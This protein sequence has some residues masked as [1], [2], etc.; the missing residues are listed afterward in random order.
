MA[1]NEINN[2]LLFYKIRTLND[3]PNTYKTHPNFEKLIRDAAHGN[4]IVAGS[5]REAMATIEAERQGLIKPVASRTDNACIDFI[6][7]D[8]R[9]YDV[10]TPPSPPPNKTFV[11]N[12]YAAGSSVLTQLDKSEPNAFT[13]KLE[14]VTV[15]LDT[16]YLTSKDREKLFNFIN[17]NA[18][19]E[20]KARIVEVKINFQSNQQAK[21]N[22]AL[23]SQNKRGR[24]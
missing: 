15:L 7:G 22:S 23:L 20:Q 16:S 12:E 5:L 4:N 24:S 19:D 9:P 10:K 13:G 1:E 18:S 8:G 11:F 17:E 3:V 2:V 14:P 6:D 21:L